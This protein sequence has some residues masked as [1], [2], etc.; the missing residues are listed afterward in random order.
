MNGTVHEAKD[1]YQNRG[2]WRSLP[3]Y[4]GKKR[5][6]IYVHNLVAFS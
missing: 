3:T 5:A 6:C 1:V 4:M 2:K